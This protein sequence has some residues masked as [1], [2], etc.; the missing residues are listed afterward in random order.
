MA[1]KIDNKK[2]LGIESVTPEV[3]KTPGQKINDSFNPLKEINQNIG[4]AN[5]L[6]KEFGVDGGIKGLIKSQ[7]ERF[8][9]NN[10]QEQAQPQNYPQ[11]QPPQP[12]QEFKQEIQ[13]QKKMKFDTTKLNAIIDLVI[14]FKGEDFKV[15]ELKEFIS[16]NQ[17]LINTILN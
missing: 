4:F 9:G 17:D 10:G 6:L 11:Y 13:Q 1:V 3:V 16:E 15:S 5:S 2:F 7:I 14:R 12:Q 8:K